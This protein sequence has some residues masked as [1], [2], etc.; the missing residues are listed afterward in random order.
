MRLAAKIILTALLA[1]ST[2]ACKRASRQQ[3]VPDAGLG[4]A[5]GAADGGPTRRAAPPEDAGPTRARDAGARAAGAPDASLDGD[6]EADSGLAAGPGSHGLR[7]YLFEEPGTFRGKVPALDGTEQA[8]DRLL[9]YHGLDIAAR[10]LMAGRAS[11]ASFSGIE[12]RFSNLPPVR[13]GSARRKLRVHLERAQEVGEEFA[14]RGL[15]MSEGCPEEDHSGS[16]VRDTASAMLEALDALEEADQATGRTGRVDLPPLPGD[17]DGGA[18][19]VPAA[20]AAGAQHGGYVAALAA[21]ARAAQADFCED[22]E[23]DWLDLLAALL[24][25]A[26]PAGP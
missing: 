11:D 6:D 13:D 3:R 22:L 7:A 18:P 20:P 16:C 10:R 21:L 4:V 14:V 26:R 17:P 9:A 8:D 15:C 24:R 2:G 19:T 5:G 1:F 12:K 25:L 23:K